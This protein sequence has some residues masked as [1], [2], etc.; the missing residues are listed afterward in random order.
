MILDHRPTVGYY[1][2]GGVDVPFQE[3]ERTK[4]KDTTRLE[5]TLQNSKEINLVYRIQLTTCDL[6][7]MKD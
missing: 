2:V 5:R 1:K 4:S 3:E 7:V 6:V